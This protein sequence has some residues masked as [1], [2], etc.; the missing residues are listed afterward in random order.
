MAQQQQQTQPQ[1]WRESAAKFFG[2]WA[3]MAVLVGGAVMLLILLLMPLLAVFPKM[4]WVFQLL[5]WAL[6]GLERLWIY[7]VLATGFFLFLMPRKQSTASDWTMKYSQ[8]P[9]QETKP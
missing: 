8:R 2:T 1:D 4:G 6:D 7:A 5:G 9:D 3:M